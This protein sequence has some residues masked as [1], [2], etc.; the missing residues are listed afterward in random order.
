M[1]R[2]SEPIIALDGDTAGLRAGFRLI[3]LALPLLGPE[4]SLRFCLLP[5]K[6]DPDDI[7]RQGGPA[8]MTKLI[9][10]AVPLVQLFVAARNRG[11]GV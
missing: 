7:L 5:E 10:G 11:Q 8:A 6:M 1:A 9:E 2:L 3:D 4:Q